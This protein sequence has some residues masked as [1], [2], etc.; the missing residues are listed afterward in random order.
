MNSVATRSPSPSQ[1]RKE[2]EFARRE[3]DII[4]AALTLFD[5]T[6]WEDVTVE[7]IARQAEIGKG[8]LYKHFP[9]KEA[10]YAQICLQFHEDLLASFHALDRSQSI[11]ALFRAVIRRSFDVFLSNPV[12][13]RVSFYCKRFDFVERIEPEYQVRFEQLENRFDA[14]L[15]AVLENGIA[16]GLIPDRPINQ[17]MAGLEAT[18]DGAMAMVW[19]REPRDR[20]QMTDDEFITMISDF[21][22]AGL[23][24]QKGK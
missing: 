15:A 20:F 16:E 21:M 22:I 6:S 1:S 19:N 14:F 23:V 5:S 24:G 11:P 7:Q 3:Q 12:H 2:R 9:S 8:T 10:L 13:A 4:N 18:F 17:L